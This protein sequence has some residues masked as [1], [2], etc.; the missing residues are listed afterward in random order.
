LGNCEVFP[1][2]SSGPK[3]GGQKQSKKRLKEYKTL[4]KERGPPYCNPQVGGSGKGA[5]PKQ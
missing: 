1:C 4:E 5:E 3:A 2:Q